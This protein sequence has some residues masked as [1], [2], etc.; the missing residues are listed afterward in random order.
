MHLEC[1]EEQVGLVTHALLQALELSTVQ[2]IRQDWCVVRVRALL[3]NDTCTL[4]GT[5]ATH[6]SKT[7]LRNNHIEIV[8]GLV[9]VCS[10]GNDAGDTGGVCLGGA[11]T[12]CVH[13]TVLRRTQEIGRTAETV[14]HARAHNARA[15]SV[16]VDV[17]FNGSVHA[18]AAQTT[19]DLRRVRNLLRAQEQ[20]AGIALPVVVEALE[21]IG[22]EADGS[23]RREVEV[24]AVEEIEER[25]LENLGPHLEVGK[26]CATL[27]E[28]ANDGVGDVSNTGLD[29]KKVRGETAMLDFMLQEFNEV[30]GDGLGVGVFRRVGLSLVRVVGFDNGDDLLRVDGD[31]RGSDTVF[32]LED[33]VRL[34]VRG[35]L[36]HG[37]VV[38]TLKGGAGGVDLNDDLVRH[39]DELGR[40]TD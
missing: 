8:L 11:D 2:V 22:G 27:A 38:Q 14:E 21:A 10:E 20:L 37:D 28:A 17:D 33:Q 23:R 34:A 12:R 32:G 30:G 7:L 19:D 35:E 25:V 9:N 4:T 40:C 6:I 3:D 36:G 24:A 26:V 15:V 39:L 1:V 16:G 18:D 29:G 31:V 5:Q 13:D